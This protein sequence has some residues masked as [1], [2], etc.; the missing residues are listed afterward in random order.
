MQRSRH[1]NQTVV[2]A[3]HAKGKSLEYN[4]EMGATTRRMSQFDETANSMNMTGDRDT[5]ISKN[6]AVEISNRKS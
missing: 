4:H 3:S 2:L 1:N 6:I 5:E